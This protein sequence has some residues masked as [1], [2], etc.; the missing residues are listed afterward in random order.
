MDETVIPFTVVLSGD[1]RRKELCRKIAEIYR[2]IPG[3]RDV[4]LLYERN[5]AIAFNKGAKIADTDILFCSGGDVLVKPLDVM[6]MVREVGDN[7]VLFIV[8]RRSD[9]PLKII[10][11]FLD[12]YNRRKRI[13][14]CSGAFSVKRETI[15]KCPI[16]EKPDFMEEV[17]WP[18]KGLRFKPYF[19]EYYHIHLQSFSHIFNMSIKRWRARARGRSKFLLYAGCVKIFLESIVIYLEQRLAFRDKTV[20]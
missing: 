2:K 13:L 15:L 14:F 11:F 9:H 5:P 12:F 1:P 20:L 4:L 6:R 18:Q 17:L 16:P 10:G 3:A 19:G 7:E 8:P